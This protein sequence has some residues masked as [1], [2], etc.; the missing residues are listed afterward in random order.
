MTN[1]TLG[2]DKAPICIELNKPPLDPVYEEEMKQLRYAMLLSKIKIALEKEHQNDPNCNVSG[3]KDELGREIEED[4]SAENEDEDEDD[5]ND[6]NVDDADDE[7]DD[8][9]DDG[10]NDDQLGNEG[11]QETD[12]ED[13][14]TFFIGPDYDTYPQRSPL[15]KLPSDSD[16]SE[17]VSTSHLEDLSR[18]IVP[19]IQ[20]IDET[21]IKQGNESMRE[22]KLEASPIL[23][24]SAS[25]GKR[26]APPQDDHMDTS[27]TNIE[28]ES[29]AESPRTIMNI[30][31]GTVHSAE[32][33][34]MQYLALREK[35]TKVMDDLCKKVDSPIAAQSQPR[36]PPPAQPQPQQQSQSDHKILERMTKKLYDLEA[37]LNKVARQQH[38]IKHSHF[39]LKERVDLACT[40]IDTYQDNSYQLGEYALQIL[41]YA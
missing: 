4:E 35:D 34:H 24:S 38:E 21:P 17:E 15:R 3:T 11:A 16:D 7:N 14:H 36:S 28:E 25:G 19:H 2:R 22:G 30:M 12:P 10:D 39:G 37:S 40:K 8:D 6:D 33:I 1:R 13:S 18:A 27:P 41:G 9:D 20:P 26:E 29:P 31:R 5:N 32:T 23:L